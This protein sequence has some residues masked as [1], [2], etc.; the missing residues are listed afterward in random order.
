MC[1]RYAVYSSPKEVAKIFGIKQPFHLNQSYNVAPTENIS[2]VVQLGEEERR[3]V[4]M[5]EL[6]P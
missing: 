3:I 2:V 4:T 6:K 1:G 5:L